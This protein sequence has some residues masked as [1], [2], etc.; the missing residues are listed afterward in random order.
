MRKLACL[1]VSLIAGGAFSAATVS[2]AS[3]TAYPPPCP[4]SMLVHVGDG[5][6][7]V[8]RPPAAKWGR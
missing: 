7:T 3:A 6:V 8:T 5:T 4:V 2:T 1:A